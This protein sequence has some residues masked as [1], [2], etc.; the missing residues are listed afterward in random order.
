MNAR[1]DLDR[2]LPKIDHSHLDW[3]EEEA[4][5]ILREVAATFERPALLFSG[6][7]DSCVVLRLA[8]KAFKTRVQGNEFKGRLPFPLLHV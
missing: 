6:G 4:I 8:E 7:K 5:F 3:L 1:V 2:L